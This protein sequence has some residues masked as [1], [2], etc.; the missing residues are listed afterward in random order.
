MSMNF[1][2]MASVTSGEGTYRLLRET[3]RSVHKVPETWEYVQ[4]D[5]MSE[6]MIHQQY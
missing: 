6:I 2:I 1:Y 3:G 4:G 5:N